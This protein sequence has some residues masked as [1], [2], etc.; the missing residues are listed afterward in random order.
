MDITKVPDDEKLRLCKW[1]FKVGFLALPF[2]WAVNFC[3]FFPIA[4]KRGTEMNDQQK[5]IR[6]Y[7]IM[8]GIGAFL[9]L[10][11]AI[12]WI[13]IFQRYR[14][15]WGEFADNISFIIPLGKV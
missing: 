15:E 12:V 1:Y 3:W 7:T 10:G 13:A 6:K 11:A 8:S 14:S 2:V 4:F 9:W 5:S